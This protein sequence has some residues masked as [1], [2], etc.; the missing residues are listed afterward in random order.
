MS[1]QS[2]L[3][4]LEVS[5][6]P[7]SLGYRHFVTVDGG[8]TYIEN[9]PAPR[10]NPLPA[11]PL[12]YRAA[13][14][15]GNGMLPEG[16]A[17]I[18]AAELAAIEAAGWDCIVISYGAWGPAAAYPAQQYAGLGGRRSCRSRSRASDDH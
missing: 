16:A 11:A 1:L 12:D 18:T 9:T 2:R 3:A 10:A 7:E 8:E 17:T 6:A 14:V 13:L 4:K 5:L 15:G